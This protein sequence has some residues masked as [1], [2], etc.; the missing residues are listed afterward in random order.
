MAVGGILSSTDVA[1]PSIFIP[2]LSGMIA[3]QCANARFQG[4]RL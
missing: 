2:R 4:T 3:I 1:A